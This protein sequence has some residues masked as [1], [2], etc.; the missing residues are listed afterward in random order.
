MLSKPLSIFRTAFSQSR[1][2][3]SPT[4]RI[5][6]YAERLSVLSSPPLAEKKLARSCLAFAKDL[7]SALALKLPQ[8]D[9]SS[10]C[11]LFQRMAE[12]LYKLFLESRGVPF[13][14]EHSLSQLHR[15]IRAKTDCKTRYIERLPGSEVSSLVVITECAIETIYQ[16]GYEMSCEKLRLHAAQLDPSIEDIARQ[17]KKKPIHH[18]GRLLVPLAAQPSFPTVSKAQQP[19]DVAA[20]LQS[21]AAAVNQAAEFVASIPD[22]AA[23]ASGPAASTTVTTEAAA[24]STSSDYSK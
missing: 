13:P 5:K 12:T 10:T 9:C 11:H 15:L 22:P 1:Q 8:D 21:V 20:L 4:V 24:A 3:S 17:L 18:M 2:L 16:H 7:D 23:A 14:Y 6:S 19:E